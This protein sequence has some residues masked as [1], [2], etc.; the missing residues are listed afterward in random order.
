MWK[1]PEAKSKRTM[2]GVKKGVFGVTHQAPRDPE[3]SKVIHNLA[4]FLPWPD[5][6]RSI[7]RFPR[8][9]FGKRTPLTPPHKVAFLP[10]MIFARLL[11]L[12][13]FAGVLLGLGG[14]ATRPE[15]VHLE[16]VDVLPL[17]L[18]N[19]F[20]IRKIKRFYLSPAEWEPTTSQA[21]NFERRHYLWGAVSAQ[22]I[23]AI[24]GNYLDVFWRASERADV[25]VRLEYRQLGSGSL[26][27]AQELYYPAAR[28]SYTSKFSVIGDEFLEFGRVSA[29]RVLLIV[30]GK[31]VNFRQS[32]L[33]R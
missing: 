31:I 24:S 9:P 8:R 11:L 23:R 32:F 17:S 30:D 2:L 5:R 29:W 4:N 22:E 33:W 7:G 16:K 25:T 1:F 27:S 18:D 13:L 12:A 21:A 15:P 19:R 14:C 6:V 28:G 26:V 20:Q 3:S 10:T